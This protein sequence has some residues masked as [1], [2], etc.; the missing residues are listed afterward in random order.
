MSSLICWIKRNLIDYIYAGLIFLSIP[1]YFLW[2]FYDK[3]PIF[4]VIIFV[5]SLLKFNCFKKNNISFFICIALVFLYVALRA[6]K[7]IL[8][9]IASL[10]IC[11]AVLFPASYLHSVI[12]KFSKIY[13]FAITPSIFVYILVMFLGVSLSYNIIEPLNVVKDYDYL[14]YPFLLINNKLDVGT[15][16]FEAYFDEPGVVGTISGCLLLMRGLRMK[17]WE[18]WPILISGVLSLSLAFFVM[19]LANIAIFQ[20]TKIKLYFITIFFGLAFLLSTDEILGDLIF[21]RITIEDG[22][23]GGENRT[24]GSME[25]FYQRFVGSEQYIFGYGNGYSEKVVNFGGASYKDFI[26]NNGIFGFGLLVVISLLFGLVYLKLT[27]QYLVFIFIFGSI[28]YQRPFITHLLYFS[29]IYL[30]IFYMQIDNKK[31]MDHL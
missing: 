26:V 21:D 6:D 7:N 19:L 2:Q 25:V 5:L 13:A 17:R 9:I 4:S 15:F 11:S 18:F 29:L 3:L 28:I 22:R 31:Q 30:S 10:L 23:L 16:R 20:K 24:T 12:D 14:Q 8:G 27:K 1:P